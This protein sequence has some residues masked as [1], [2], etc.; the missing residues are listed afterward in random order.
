M[1]PLHIVALLDIVVGAEEALF[2]VND[3]SEVQTPNVA[4]TMTVPAVVVVRVVPDIVAATL[5]GARLHVGTPDPV[6]TVYVRL[7][8][9]PT[10]TVLL[11]VVFVTVDTCLYFNVALVVSQTFPQL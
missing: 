1:P 5:P 4:L 8:L 3:T 11:F 10:H 9:A 6:D 7:L 2:T